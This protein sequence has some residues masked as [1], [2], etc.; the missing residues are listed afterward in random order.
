MTGTIEERFE[1]ILYHAFPTRSTRV[2]WLLL[3]I[4]AEDTVETRF[5]NLLEGEQH[6]EEITRIN[7]M[8][9][10]PILTLNE[11]ATQEEII[12]TESGAICT[13]LTDNL[14][15]G[16]MLCPDRSNIAATAVY[17]RVI[18]LATSSIDVLLWQIRQHETLLSE[19]DRIPDVA[20]GAR[21]TYS[22]RVVPTVEAIIKDGNHFVCSPYHDEFTAA[23]IVLAYSLFWADLYDLNS[24]KM[25]TYLSRMQARASFQR[26]TTESDFLLSPITHSDDEP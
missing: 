7:P 12:M 6:D 18:S 10:V 9:A 24:E 13:F 22:T 8:Q 1:V 14:Q 26:M 16:H 20:H 2:R 17:H 23:D 25:K 21:E 4:E 3:E 11:R 19:Q 15:N 5:V